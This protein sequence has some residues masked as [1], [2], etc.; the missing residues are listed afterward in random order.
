LRRFE[1]FGGRADLEV[2][3]LLATVRRDLRTGVYAGRQS[4]V[5]VVV[6]HLAPGLPLSEME[7]GTSKLSFWTGQPLHA[8]GLALLL[9]FSGGAWA[10]IAPLT[11]EFL[12]IGSDKWF[13]GAIAVPVVHQTYVWICWRLELLHSRAVSRTVGFTGY[14][15]G[16]FVLIAGRLVPF[17]PLAWANR[18]SLN[19]PLPARLIL[20]ALLLVLSAY[21]MY[22]VARYFGMSR[23]AG[24]DHFDERYRTMPLV[25]EGIFR[26]TSNGMY[27]VAFLGP[28]GLALLLGSAGA[29]IAAAFGHAYIWLHF[30]A[31]E[32]P[33]MNFIYGNPQ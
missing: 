12:G 23:A 5:P 19:L 24:A 1:A 16:F 21:A 30:C 33:D 6:P 7:P 31:T 27:G 9:L 14:E 11:G 25:S 20:G 26:W 3:R 18:D 10:A 22:S 32:R 4:A 17:V 15:A 28:W 8:A 13:W 29:L 2:T